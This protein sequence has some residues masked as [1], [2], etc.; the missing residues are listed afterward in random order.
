MIPVNLFHYLLIHLKQ[1]TECHIIITN[2]IKLTFYA[3]FINFRKLLFMISA[4]SP[5]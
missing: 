1:T 5:F 4:D 3:V 2:I